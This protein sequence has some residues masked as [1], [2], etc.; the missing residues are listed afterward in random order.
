MSLQAGES[1]RIILLN[2]LDR[3]CNRSG[4]IGR[5]SVKVDECDALRAADLALSLQPLLCFSCQF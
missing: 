1:S 4:E 5:I 3:G 2:E